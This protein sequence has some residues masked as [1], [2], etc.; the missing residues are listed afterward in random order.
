MEL[1]DSFLLT[2]VVSGDY[3]QAGAKEYSYA[4]TFIVPAR[5]KS[6]EFLNSSPTQVS[7]LVGRMKEGWAR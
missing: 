6:I 4:E 1:K 2:T 3:V 5:R 7:L